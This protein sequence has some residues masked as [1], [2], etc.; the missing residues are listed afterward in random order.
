M[1]LTTVAA[2][3]AR[4]DEAEKLP[5]SRP[6]RFQRSDFIA[7]GIV[8]FV[9]LVVYI[10][11]LAP[12]VT[13]EDSGELITGAT[14]FGVPHP[15]G[16]PLWTM[17]GFLISHLLP[18]GG[19]A[20]RVNLLSALIGGAGNAIVT[21][22]VCHSGR[23]LL[24]RW[25]E[26]ALQPVVR[27]FAFYAGLLAGFTIGF[28]NV[29][30]GQAVIA[31][32]H[33]TLNA[34]FVDLVLFFFYLW[35]IE[36]QKTNRLVYTVLVFS[37]GLTNHHTLIQII[38]AILLAV[39]LL[40]AG[41]FWSVF[42]AVNFFSLTILVYLSWLAADPQLDLIS[43]RMAVII[44]SMTTVVSLYYLKQFRAR[45]FLGGVVVAALF[46]LYAHYVMGPNQFDTLRY[47][48]GPFW[49]I[50][51]L[52]HPGWLQITGSW[53]VFMLAFAAL[54]TGLLLTCSLDRRLI[55]GVFCAGWVG[56]TPYAYESFASSTNPPM[57]WGFASER[58]GFYYA[59][60]RQQYPMSLPN[61]I[62][63]TLGKALEV[64]PRGAQPD[65]GLDQS[66][67]FHRLWLTFFYY[68]DNLQANLTVPLLV[69]ALAILIYV[70]RCDR[71]QANWLLFL[72]FAW[73]FVGFM[74]QLIEPQEG[75]DFERN[76]QY[77][78]FQIQSHCV[79]VILMGYGALAAMTFIQQEWPQVT[80]RTGPL[81]LGIP[82][83][84]LSL[85]PF[86]SNV[87]SCNQAGHWFGYDFGADVI[88]PMEKNAVYFGGSDFGRFVPTYMVFVESQQ[89]DGWKV[90]PGFDRRDVSVIT[91]NA[92][93]DTFYCHYI[94][95]QYD[96]RFRPRPE[97]YT[98]F[99]KW[100]GRDAAYPKEP[101]T[102]MSESELSDCWAEF[103]RRPEV[104]ERIKRGE[105]VLRENTQD[106]FEVNGIV[107]R[108]IFQKN[109]AK[110]AFYLEQSVA[111]PWMYPY[112]L[113]SGLI[114]KLNPEPMKSLPQAAIDA[115]HKF[116]DNYT[117]RLL[118]DPG[119]RADDHA[120]DT[121]GKLAAW[122]ADLYHYR[123]LPKE[124]E[125]WLKLALKLCPQLQDSVANLSRLLSSQKRFD[126][127]IAVVNQG[128]LDDPRNETYGPL[129]DGLEIGKS[130]GDQEK[131]VRAQLGQTAKS[132][133]DVALNLQLAQVL[134]DEGKFAELDQRLATIAGL[135]NWDNPGV[136]GVVE[137]YMN[138][139]HDPDAAIAFLDARAK[140]DPK[141]SV[142]VYDLAAI[143]A[144]LGHK[145]EAL[146]F[147]G[148]A[149]SSG[150]GT[151]ALMS[152]K[153]DPR[154][155]GFQKDA[156]F[157]AMVDRG[158]TNGPVAAPPV[159]AK[160]APAVKH[161]KKK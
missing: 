25:T 72:V 61:L 126:E 133:Y 67:Y 152:A 87:Q 53:G 2:P 56:L 27:P 130:L 33:G 77:K 50:G 103:E 91:Q 113:P 105:P 76:L 108:Q 18:F 116:W 135:T 104:A 159:T 23:W 52:V 57:N 40:R 46:F 84:F 141:N 155:A 125:Y 71:P 98:P 20:W 19:L 16:Y 11:T 112:L 17:S 75:F 118:A 149:V 29:V 106:V 96:A 47:T 30:W 117:A 127:A 73:F 111:I 89:D 7:A 59:V 134:Q 79:L 48:R 143:H 44:L 15:P 129:L 26:E 54:A 9:T 107:A 69:L 37:L 28:S 97:Q 115:D 55:V 114:F 123:N 119:F 153:I 100:L 86:W 92:L 88:K 160:S 154:F 120:T 95:D 124:E 4:S 90:E 6:E 81:G 36:P 42:L 1:S 64:M 13:L 157:R 10:A 5:P 139:S 161:K 145:A 109:K 70:R 74:L 12:N 148:Q 122:H 151:N 140:I 43:D 24:Q 137:Y 150:G 82:A 45:W 131:K 138:H 41:K 14:K 22:I 121:F 35:L 38:P 66:G 51:T 58:A 68:G 102:C 93:C 110:H 63:D 136:A 31:A 101:V 158:M 80:S 8:F 60:S 142:M 21:L 62:K 65:A 3:I 85:L 99:E 147:L 49:Q 156:D 146:K 144:S 132:P 78:V 128:E 94:R 39:F 32:V 34:L 83:L